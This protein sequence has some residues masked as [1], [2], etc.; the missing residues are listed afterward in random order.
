MIHS[1]NYGF[2][3]RMRMREGKHAPRLRL[4]SAFHTRAHH[5]VYSI[6]KIIRRG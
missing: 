1:K 3:M 4:A 2:T 6:G 5:E